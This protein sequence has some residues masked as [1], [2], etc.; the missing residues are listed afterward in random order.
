MFS[1]KKLLKGI[2]YFT[3]YSFRYFLLISNQTQYKSK[4]PVRAFLFWACHKL[5]LLVVRLVISYLIATYYH[6]NMMHIETA[7]YTPYNSKS[8]RNKI[9][10]NYPKDLY[11]DAMLSM[12]L[13]LGPIKK[14]IR[15]KSSMFFL[16]C[17]VMFYLIE[18][19][20]VK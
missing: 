3:N 16:I 18:L 6:M 2:F 8:E 4:K 1:V 19:K 17:I 12:F 7:V 9:I 15:F 11:V 5:Q 13:Q 10:Y 14:H 20:Q